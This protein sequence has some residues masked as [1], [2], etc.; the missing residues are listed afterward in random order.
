[1]VAPGLRGPNAE[2]GLRGRDGVFGLRDPNGLAGTGEKVLDDPM[3]RWPPDAVGYARESSKATALSI[4]ATC[5]GSVIL[6][7]DPPTT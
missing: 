2:S 4:S 6:E 1:M 7:P 5:S 3:R